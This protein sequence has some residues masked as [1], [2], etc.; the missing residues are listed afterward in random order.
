[1]DKKILIVDDDTSILVLLSDILRENGHMVTTAASGEACV[2][3]L[4][5]ETFDLIVLDIMMKGLSGLDVC[6]QIRENVSAPIIFLSAKDTSQDIVRG[7]S[8][9]ADDYLTKPFV[10]EELIARIDAHLR[11][12]NRVAVT[13]RRDGVIKIGDI[14]LDLAEMTVTKSGEPV[15]LSTREYELLV[16][17]MQNA[18]QTLSKERIFRDVWQTDYG[19]I[20]TVAINIKNLRAKI[21]P[22]WQ[23]IKTVWGSGY[24]FVTQS[25]FAD[26]AEQSRQ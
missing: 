3:L 15:T 22:N 16:Y 6:R 12:E 23:Y 11:R 7:L 5:R 1:M 25:G 9:G 13:G 14:A 26:E 17:L 24:L 20:G 2:R 18:G 19:E 10:L 21:D 4:K 8:L